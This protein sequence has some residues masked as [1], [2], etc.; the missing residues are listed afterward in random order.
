MQKEA[1]RLAGHL[2][3]STDTFHVIQRVDPGSL[4]IAAHR[5]AAE[6]L[7]TKNKKQSG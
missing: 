5:A 1:I 2:V 7:Q 3:L 6:A 4:V